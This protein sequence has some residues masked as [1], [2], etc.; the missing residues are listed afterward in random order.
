MIRHISTRSRS[1]CVSVGLSPKSLWTQDFLE[2]DGWVE[3]ALIDDETL[4]DEAAEELRYDSEELGL[5]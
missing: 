2:L 1:A 4:A 3:S 5:A